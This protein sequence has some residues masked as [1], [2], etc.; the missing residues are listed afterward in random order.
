MGELHPLA[1]AGFTR[2]AAAYGRARPSYPPEA[3]DRLWQRLALAPGRTVVDVGAGTGK[4]TAPLVERGAQVLAVEPVAAMRA[5]LAEAV[6]GCRVLEGRAEALPLADASA[7]AI[8]AAQAMHWFD[9]P[10]ALPELHRV[11]R[12]GGRLGL[13]WNLWDL[14]D[15]VQATL[16]RLVSRVIPHDSPVV[17][18]T[19]ASFPSGRWM[20][21]LRQT[22]LFSGLEEARFPHVQQLERDRLV[23][24]IAS[25]SFVAALP[26]GRREGLLQ[27]VREATRELPGVVRLPFVAVAYSL[28]R[29]EA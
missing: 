5:V 14:A 12:P 13:V 25:I 15:P 19:T 10:L 3:V 8:T 2:G 9:M 7:D 27:E 22:P 6:P 18:D 1:G 11:L 28:A 17:H 21:A 16:D 29:L 26:D 4:L 24:R 23:D 20:P